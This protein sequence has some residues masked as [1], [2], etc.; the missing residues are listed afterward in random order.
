[1]TQLKSLGKEQYRRIYKNHGAP[2]NLY[3]VPISDL[4]TIVKKV[5]KNHAL[6]LEL[7]ETGQSDAMYLAGLI[8]DEKKISAA[9]LEHWA[10]TAPWY[11]ISEYTVPWV[12]AE[13]PYG[14]EL[15]LKWIES[16][17]ELIQCAGWNA[18]SGC[19]ALYPDDKIE[20]DTVFQLLGRI[21]KTIHQSLNRVRYSMNSFVIATGTYY[22]PLHDR[23]REVA[24]NVG[25]VSVDLGG[26]ACKVPFAPEYIQKVIGKGI[27][28]K[29]RK[30]VRC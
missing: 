23:A 15:G 7:Y 27:V 24:E 30:E 4:K 6:S 9:E 10:Q 21:E 13:S 26:T 3:G 2:D 11:M 12:A 28:G 5:K 17:S 19:L 18:L 1:M 25:K 20:G 8:A 16:P 29:K 22:L 14:W